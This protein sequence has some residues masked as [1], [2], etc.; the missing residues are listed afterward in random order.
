MFGYQYL[1]VKHGAPQSIPTVTVH[2]E[3]VV[4]PAPY[5]TL[6]YDSLLQSVFSMFFFVF[7]NTI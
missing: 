3:E 1:T 4:W 2:P 6:L 5:C 7:S